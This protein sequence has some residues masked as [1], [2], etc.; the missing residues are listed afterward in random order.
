M[1]IKMK[2]LTIKNINSNLDQHREIVPGLSVADLASLSM[3]KREDF[4][5]KM[6][7]EL[8]KENKKEDKLLKKLEEDFVKQISKKLL[9]TV[10]KL[11][12]ELNKKI[13]TIDEN[14]F[15]CDISEQEI[16][17]DLNL[18]NI[19]NS[20]IKAISMSFTLSS[21]AGHY[22]STIEIER[23]ITLPK[24]VEP[25]KVQYKEINK[26]LESIS[27][28][29]ILYMDELANTNKLER[30][31]KAKAIEQVVAKSEKGKEFLEKIQKEIS[32]E[33]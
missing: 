28:K 20:D 32:K 13:K 1:E 4:I 14:L 3:A 8:E 15:I 22:R 5:E 10:K 6:L 26:R 18:S 11:H 25:F 29:T 23:Q 2:E 21:S 30:K 16:K 24:E 31:F 33:Y 27:D 9:P 17:T 19:S 7:H 12:L